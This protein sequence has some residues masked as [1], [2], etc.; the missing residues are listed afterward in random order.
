MNKVTKQTQRSR[1]LQE[2]EQVWEEL[3]SR[4]PE[5]IKAAFASLDLSDQKAVLTHLKRMAR[6][7]G[8][9]PEQ[10]LSATAALDVI[11]SQPEQDTHGYHR[12]DPSDA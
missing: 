5:T 3:L 8:W 10:R 6:E 7:L 1:Q 12:A 9:Q 11:V 4:Q 2:T